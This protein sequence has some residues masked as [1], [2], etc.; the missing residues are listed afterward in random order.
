MASARQ[1]RLALKEVRVTV[2]K[3]RKLLKEDSLKT[4]RAIDNVARFVK[5]IIEPAEA[6]LESQE[7]FAE[8]AQA[9]RAAD[10]HAA[11]VEA[12]MQYTDDISLYNIDS[13]TD[14]QFE[15]ILA[16]VKAQHEAK[17]AE[18]KR[19]EKERIAK[20][21]AD[22]AVAEAQRKENERLKAEAAARD[23]KDAEDRAARAA[24][25]KKDYDKHEA[26]RKA[27]D[28][29]LALER[30]KR[31][32]LEKEQ[33]AALAQAEKERLDAEETKR[34]ALLAPDKD[35]LLALADTIENMELPDLEAEQALAVLGKVAKLLG[36]VSV[37]IRGNVKGL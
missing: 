19:L 18:A 30:Q 23:K 15:T 26:E 37:Y 3:K 21:K 14:E 17:L 12:L 28:A 22:A 29:K 5:E 25:A 7:K 11:R 2:E 20:E 9:K 1:K 13:M 31:E 6:Y 24:E 16:S 35:K 10:L 4:G 27:T 8:L 33:A 36:K 34:Q 32:A